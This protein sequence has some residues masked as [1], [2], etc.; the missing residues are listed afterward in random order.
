MLDSCHQQ[1]NPPNNFTRQN[2]V[3]LW[4]ILIGD[5]SGLNSTLEIEIY[6]C[7]LM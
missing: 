2:L 5:P 7:I 6:K 3:K 1:R 4:K